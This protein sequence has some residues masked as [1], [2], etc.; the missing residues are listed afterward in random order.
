MLKDDY[1]PLL[2]KY[3]SQ[4]QNRSSDQGASIYQTPAQVVEV[5]ITCINNTNPPVRIRTS[6][7]AEQFCEIKTQADPD[8]RRLAQQIQKEFL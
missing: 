4:S 1:L 8:G 3:I 6:K 5:I 2:Q 7:W